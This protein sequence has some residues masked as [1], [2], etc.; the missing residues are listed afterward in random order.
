MKTLLHPKKLLRAI[1]ILVLAAYLPASAEVI[2]LRD[3]T[4]IVG[5]ITDQTET[6]LTVRTSYGTLTIEKAN[7]L[8]I[9]YSAGGAQ[10]SQQP[11]QQII[12]QQQQQQQQ[13]EQ[14]QQVGV[15]SSDEFYRGY[16]DGKAKGYEDG[17]QKGSQEM[18]SQRLSG[19]LV[20][21]L[22]E[23]AL[24]LIIIISLSSSSY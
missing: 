7:V 1:A 2:T 22:V 15:P 3:G 4:K 14:Q 12:I 10:P 18:K 21:W 23:T 11:A 19:A 17:Y 6:K 8:S 24:A 5:T 13:E 16:R 20:G 9:D